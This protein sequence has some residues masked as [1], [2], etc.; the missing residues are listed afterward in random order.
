MQLT[1]WVSIQD[2]KFLTTHQP[3]LN[4]NSC[5]NNL[6]GLLCFTAEHNKKKL[7]GKYLVEVDFSKC[8]PLPIVKELGGRIKS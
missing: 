6:S 2:Q 8:T 1:S 4:Y 7:G 3:R 5:E